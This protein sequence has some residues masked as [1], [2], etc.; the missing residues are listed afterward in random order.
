MLLPPIVMN[1]ILLN[2]KEKFCFLSDLGQLSLGSTTG[3]NK[4]F[5]LDKKR[6]QEYNLPRE[7][8]IP[9]TKSPKDSI[10]LNK[11]SSKKKKFLLHIPS[12]VEPSFYP[13]LQA[14]I[15]ENKKSIYSRPYFKNKK[16]N[17]WFRI[18][19]SQPDLMIPNMTYLR[20][21]VIINKGNYH[22]DKQWIGFWSN[23]KSWLTPL[24]GFFNSSLGILLREVQGTKTL[25]LGSLKLSLKECNDLLILDPR[26]MSSTTQEE[27]AEIITKMME[28]PLLRIGEKG[29]FREYQMQLDD[30]FNQ[31]ILKLSQASKEEIDST[32]KFFVE[33]R[34]GRKFN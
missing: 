25:G 17:S 22:I 2:N 26:K 6:I 12:S 27:I 16:E 10:T 33:W 7:F 15:S 20:S 31:K 19:L 29:L 23:K 21:F 4:F 30:I 32:I 13:E 24:L 5:Y 9:M 8:L 28:L 3:A 34:L 1:E 14:Y 18:R 11:I